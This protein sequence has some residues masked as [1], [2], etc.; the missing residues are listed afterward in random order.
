M[1][2]DIGYGGAIIGSL[3]VQ[4][5][6]SSDSMDTLVRTLSDRLNTLA[7]E[8]ISMS[9]RIHGV[10]NA[11]AGSGALSPAIPAWAEELR[12]MSGEA[13]GRGEYAMKEIYRIRETL[14]L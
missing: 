3:N 10:Q 11:S 9:E 14:G 2:K 5:P 7:R 6:P 12:I 4:S 13:H 1:D 8:V